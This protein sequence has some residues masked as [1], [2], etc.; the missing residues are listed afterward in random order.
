M[1]SSSDSPHIGF[2]RSSSRLSLQ[3]DLDDCDYSCPFIVDDVDMSGA[4]ASTRLALITVEDIVFAWIPRTNSR[5]GHPFVCR[6]ITSN[7]IV[8]TPNAFM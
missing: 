4:N 1:L 7:S 5:H 2:S 3:E 6:M 8:Q